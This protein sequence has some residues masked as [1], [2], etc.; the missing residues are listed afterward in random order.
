MEVYVMPAFGFPVNDGVIA[1]IEAGTKLSGAES[2]LAGGGGAI[3]K[4]PAIAGAAGL[5]L[6]G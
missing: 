6:P 2:G 5:A 1:G 4:L 3:P